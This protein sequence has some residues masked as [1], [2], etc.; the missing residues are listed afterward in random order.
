MGIVGKR[1]ASVGEKK[2][3]KN[4]TELYKLYVVS[5]GLT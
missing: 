2:R 1:D 5:K 3:P 4:T